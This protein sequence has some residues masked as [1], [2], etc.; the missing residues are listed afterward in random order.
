[1]YHVEVGVQP[2]NQR[3]IVDDSRGWVHRASTDPQK[4]CRQLQS[5]D[6]SLLMSFLVYYFWAVGPLLCAWVVTWFRLLS[7]SSW[8]RCKRLVVFTLRLFVALLAKKKSNPDRFCVCFLLGAYCT[9]VYQHMYIQWHGVQSAGI[10][11]LFKLRLLRCSLHVLYITSL[12][13]SWLQ[14][15]NLPFLIAHYI[16]FG[17]RDAFPQ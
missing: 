11:S 14:P 6:W 4:S 3:V 16:L 13:A 7:A 5:A 15:I 12:V 10:G 2:I 1:M 8:V 17:F 9:V